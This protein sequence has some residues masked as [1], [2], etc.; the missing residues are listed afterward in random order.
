MAFSFSGGEA[1]GRLALC[2][3]ERPDRAVG[4]PHPRPAPGITGGARECR[5][6]DLGIG[7]A[8][9]EGTLTDEISD[10]ESTLAEQGQ[11]V[12]HN[13]AEVFD[14]SSQIWQGF[15]AAQLEKGPPKHADPLHTLPAFTELYRTM[16]D[17]PKEV[18]DKTGKS[19]GAVR[20][21][22]TRVRDK[23][24]KRTGADQDRA[25]TTL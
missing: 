7:A 15:L 24:R 1:G 19:R 25:A 5:A 9:G 17:N 11:Q 18:A 8:P 16:L 22:I 14:I 3:T 6:I 21:T 10:Q 23:L 12:A 13:M 2:R 20:M 4:S